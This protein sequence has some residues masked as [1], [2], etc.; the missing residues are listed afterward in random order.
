MLMTPERSEKSPPS[1][2]STS[3]VASLMVEAI[4]E[5]VK[6]SLIQLG[7]QTL[8]WSDFAN[9]PFE[10]R[11]RCDEKNDDSLKDLYDVFRDVLRKTVDVDPA[12]LQNREQQRRE[13][14]ADG[15]IASE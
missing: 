11:L 6:M 8:R 4:K 2:A 9:Q 13:D 14:H 1:A 15:M 10:E 7:P 5:K 3:G 12:V